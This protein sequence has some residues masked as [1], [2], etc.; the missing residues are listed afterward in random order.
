MLSP[1]DC[2][3][4]LPLLCGFISLVVV[5][6]GLVWP[7]KTLSSSRN[8][9]YI[10]YSLLILRLLGCLSLI[11]LSFPVTQ[12]QKEE[13]TTS[14]IWP[15]FVLFT[16]TSLLACFALV[17]P[18]ARHSLSRHM[19]WILF[20]AFA[21]DFFVEVLPMLAYTSVRFTL[22]PK[23][24]VLFVIGIVIPLVS[25][26]LYFPIMSKEQTISMATPE[27]TASFLSL[28]TYSYLDRLMF[29]AYRSKS[30]TR[31]QLPPLAD[32]DA[33]L[34]LRETN[35]PHI[36]RF[37]GA[38]RRH[39]FFSL[40]HIFR[41]DYVL[42]TL[43][44]IVKV[45]AG[46]LS[47]I[48]VNRVLD[49]LETNGREI[50]VIR[51]GFW[52]LLL[53]LGPIINSIA[54]QWYEFIGTRALVRA[55]NLITQLC[56]E[57]A[58]RTRISTDQIK[59]EDSD[60]ADDS[61][62]AGM[63]N[64][65]ITTDLANITE[66][67]Y[68]LLT[69][70]NIP[71][72]IGLCIAFLYVVLGW[73]SFVGLAGLLIVFPIPI[74]VSKRIQVIQEVLMKKTDARMQTVVETLNLVRM[75]KLFGWTERTKGKISDKRDTELDFLR[76][77]KMMQ[78]INDFLND[79]PHVHSLTLV[80]KQEL[81]AS[82]V[83]SSITVFDLI[84]NQIY[85]VLRDITK[86]ITG[87]VSLDRMNNFVH[88]APLL[89]QYSDDSLEQ[90]VN[91]EVIGFRQATFSWS[92]LAENASKQFQLRIDDEL[93][94]E[95]NTVN[96]LIGPTGSGKTSMLMALLGEMHFS[97][98]GPGAYHSLPRNGG[99][100]YCAQ[101][102][103]V[104]N[105]TIRA[106]ILFRSGPLDQPRYAKVLYQCGLEPDLALF[107]AGDLTELGEKG[108]TLS[109]GQKARIS[110]AR[111]CYSQANIVLLDDVLAA[112]DVHTAKWVVEKC[113][114]GDIMRGR[115]TILVSHHVGLTL[116]IAGFV[117]SLGSDGRVMSQGRVE[118]SLI[119]NLEAEAQLVY[120]EDVVDATEQ[121]PSRSGKIII[122]EEVS[123]GKVGWSTFKLYL[124][125]LGGQYPITFCVVFLTSMVLTSSALCL[126]TYY[127][128]QWAE[129]YDVLPPD[130]VPIFYYLILSISIMFSALI[131]RVIG[132][133]A[134]TF[135]GVRASKSISKA[136]MDSVMGA[137]LRWLEITPSSRVITRATQD[138]KAID[139]DI[140]DEL[141]FV[142][143]QAVSIA[144]RFGMVIA[145][146]PAAFLPILLLGLFG[147][148]F[149]RIYIRAQLSVK[150]AFSVA[151][152][153]VLGHFGAAVSALPSVRA[154]G[155]QEWF[156]S[157]S[158][159]RL[160]GYTQTGRTYYCLSRW[161]GLR[162]DGISAL[163]SASLASY[164]VYI[165]HANSSSTGFALNMAVGL[166]DS[167]L[168]LVTMFNELEVSCNSLERIQQYL[169][170]EQEPSSDVAPPAYW[171]A[172]GEL[173]IENLSAKYSEH[174]PEVL[175]NIS[176]TI[177]SGEKVGIVGRTGSGKSSLTL[178]LLR[179]ILTCG[180]VYYD[181]IE[182]SAIA[183]E[184]LRSSIA[185]IPQSPELLASTLR[186]NLDPFSMY[187][188][189]VLNNALR[190][191]GLFSLQDG[192]ISLDTP[193]ASEGN[194]L[195]L[196]ECQIIALARA[197]VKLQNQSKLLILDEATSAIDYQTDALIQSVL[198]N[199]LDGVTVI[200]VAHRLQTCMDA[201]KIIVMDA[202]RIAEIGSPSELIKAK[203][204][205][206][207]MV[208]ES[209][210]R[211]E[212]L[213]LANS[214]NR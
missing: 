189:A 90:E 171:P 23:T 135:G 202:G 143:D 61:N 36:D 62:R 77:R 172:S 145:S 73:S 40:M 122:E 199:E 103:W 170:I 72:Q 74:M 104:M 191:A 86:A 188:D 160:D 154:Y 34:Y 181:G 178:A 58:L 152:A 127:L 22:L 138:I 213:K 198:R 190:S 54:T 15:E 182:T 29:L 14:N 119:G 117:V 50:P 11:T 128:G 206:A 45:P 39:I 35:F 82:K 31:D 120:V 177:K 33:A 65:L 27:Q 30:L 64:N 150:R 105:D 123:E 67:R 63:M 146:A 91:P 130:E 28:A 12:S 5:L 19:S 125:A 204:K 167:L 2:L 173:R 80:M 209:K 134:Y 157:E 176:F 55:E 92:P 144:I 113:L 70:L 57:H 155:A 142:V 106:N 20:V 112:L 60:A 168:W 41:K 187:D 48:A 81:N 197:I 211:D 88:D 16:Y 99:V 94:F 126:Q 196:G 115:T 51:P 179:G 165:Q 107:Q 79:A 24:I 109:G 37:S 97:K 53:F 83:F 96:L 25:P 174:G 158:R 95:K 108:I 6:I 203:G 151:K 49:Y 9:G 76:K 18:A 214:K 71:L 212:L 68:F 3:R 192:R 129:A 194:S 10:I 163:F 84:R 148:G 116:P 132:F 121:T 201:D 52:I 89:D 210:D 159:R 137:T 114:Q 66:A 26:R 7:A 46:F 186:E 193:I 111:A 21:V 156:I 8:A 141:W 100:A 184:N 59:R 4:L 87:K 207:A 44:L 69:A 166:T 149:S 175:H 98:S 139:I 118:Q 124:G 1:E 47:P 136:L 195:S 32:T 110:L 101:N 43:M 153:P 169:S 13:M 85:F 56:F 162:L 140:N 17:L 38:K 183:L 131:I 78:M 164:M 180:K 75:I 185:L 133:V 161:I 200:S 208:D 42:L 205:L 93:V 102:P 147:Y